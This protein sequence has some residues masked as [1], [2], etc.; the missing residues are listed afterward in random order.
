MPGIVEKNKSDIKAKVI[1]TAVIVMAVVAAGVIFVIQKGGGAGNALN[2]KPA[3]NNSVIPQ[4]NSQSGS[5]TN[6][7]GAVGKN[8]IKF[9]AGNFDA[10]VLNYKG[11]VLVDFYASWC[12]HCK[13]IAGDVT[14]ASDAL[15]GQAEVGKLDVEQ[16]SAITK[17]YGI[18]ST[19]T[20]IVFKNGKE[21]AR[22]VGEKTKDELISL[23]KNNL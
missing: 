2:A 6:D 9:D 16:S 19:P 23:V 7:A 5:E 3:Q 17:K 13:K 10:K 11:V 21:T 8:E 18:E 1:I 22:E 14:A 20:F 15:V 4:T 12:P